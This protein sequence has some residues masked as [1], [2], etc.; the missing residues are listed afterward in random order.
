MT[1]ALKQDNDGGLTL[2]E[3]IV[4][5]VVSGIVIVTI[6]TIFINSWRTQ[7]QVVSTTE[8]TNRGQVVASMIERAMRNALFFEVSEGG[9]VGATGNVLRVRTSLTGTLRCQAFQLTE[10]ASPAFGTMH[11]ATGEL[12]LS[13]FSPWKTGIAKQGTTAYFEDTVGIGK[14]SLT[15]TFQIETDASPVSFTGDIAPRSGDDTKGK[16]GCW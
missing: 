12:G 8:A 3:L 5:I 6:G 13:A 4:A 15:Y 16:D 9:T 14:R 11:L 2:I 1:S 7:E 10:G